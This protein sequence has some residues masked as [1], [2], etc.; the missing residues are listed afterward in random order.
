MDETNRRW[1]PRV[2]LA[3]ARIAWAIAAVAGPIAFLA[4]IG[5]LISWRDG[6][7]MPELWVSTS[8]AAVGVLTGLLWL[9]LAPPPRQ[10]AWIGAV[11][12]VSSSLVTLFWIVVITYLIAN[13]Q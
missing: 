3:A 7:P 1:E 12:L 9:G 8:A 6:D 4:C 5:A 13:S 11:G 2:L 10:S